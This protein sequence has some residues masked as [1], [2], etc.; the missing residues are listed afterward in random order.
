MFIEEEEEERK[1]ILFSVFLFFV[2][3]KSMLDCDSKPRYSDIVLYGTTQPHDWNSSTLGN[4][5]YNN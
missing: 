2:T 1:K 3:H 4:N 5:K